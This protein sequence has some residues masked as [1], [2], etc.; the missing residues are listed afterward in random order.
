MNAYQRAFYRRWR[1]TCFIR[2]PNLWGRPGSRTIVFSL[3]ELSENLQFLIR[4]DIRSEDELKKKLSDL[5]NERKAARSELSS[6]K[7]R[8][9]RTDICRLVARRE[10]LKDKFWRSADEDEEL[11][12]LDA[13]IEKIMPVGKAVKYRSSLIEKKAACISQ[14]R[15]IRERDRLLRNIEWQ[16]EDEQSGA[17][18][19]GD[20]REVRRQHEEELRRRCQ[21]KQKSPEEPE[22]TQTVK[23]YQKE[24]VR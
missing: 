14:M 3:E 4:E 17:L 8:L 11:D 16:F 12:R 7:T 5:G 6:I 24:E 21:E 19:R 1:N 15:D 22:E 2:K 23:S 13:E 9:Y 10:K 18:T 20:Y